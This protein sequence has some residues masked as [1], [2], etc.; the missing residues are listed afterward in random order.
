MSTL[1]ISSFTYSSSFR[2]HYLLQLQIFS[3]NPTPSFLT[4]F[5]FSVF[6]PLPLFL[7]L[8]PLLRPAPSREHSR[9]PGLHC[10]WRRRKKKHARSPWGAGGRTGIMKHDLRYQSPLLPLSS[11]SPPTRDRTRVERLPMRY[12]CVRLAAPVVSRMYNSRGP[13]RGCSKRG[14]AAAQE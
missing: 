3:F 7:T 5:F 12:T 8:S 14:R 13:G 9:V 2:F 10:R 6:L 1:D 11:C 4:F